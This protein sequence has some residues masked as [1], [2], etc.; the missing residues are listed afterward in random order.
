MI[1]GVGLAGLTRDE[2]RTAEQLAVAACGNALQDAGVGTPDVDGLLLARSPTASPAD[3][4]VSLQRTLGLGPLRLA[5][6]VDAKGASAAVL[7]E[8]AAAYITAGRAR[9]VLCLFADA[10]RRVG[11]RAREVFGHPVR[12]TDAPAL[13]ALAGLR[14]PVA[15]FALLAQMYLDAHGGVET[16][17]LAVAQ[18]AR[19]RA[20]RNPHALFPEPLTLED[21]VSSPWVARPLRRLD[22]SMPVN[23]AAALVVTNE[24]VAA[25][26]DRRAVQVLGASQA[27]PRTGFAVAG[28]RRSGVRVAVDRALETAGVA[29]RDVSRLQLYDAVTVLP[30]LAV[31]ELGLAAPGDGRR[32]LLDAAVGGTAVRVNEGGGQLGGYYL[33]GMTPVVEAVR[34]LRASTA[35]QRAVGVAVASGG[36]FDR[37]AAL[38]LAA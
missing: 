28:L 21:Y 12:L 16:S 13:D 4:S 6:V 7:V 29:L 36:M 18:A 30:V 27:H 26:L 34:E 2:P 37:H 38:V 19:L 23:G 10:P 31:E 20:A 32:W 14:G 5:T 33:Q 17:F 35:E 9:T 1:V 24:P 15:A 8:L 3:V 25:R 11:D 22:C